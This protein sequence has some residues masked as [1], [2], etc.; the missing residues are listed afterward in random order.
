MLLTRNLQN[1]FRLF[2]TSRRLSSV[3][4][5]L[6]PNITCKETIQMHSAGQEAALNRFLIGFTD[7]LQFPVFA[8]SFSHFKFVD[9]CVIRVSYIL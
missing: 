5:S 8:K 4:L 2:L 9:L 7:Y 3:E 6:W 1:Y